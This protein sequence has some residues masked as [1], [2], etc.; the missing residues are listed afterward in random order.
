[1]H[2]NALT[3][4]V[5]VMLTGRAVGYPQEVLPRPVSTPPI[6]VSGDVQLAEVDVNRKAVAF[7]APEVILSDMRLV[8]WFPMTME[9]VEEASYAIHLLSLDPIEDSKGT[10]LLTE[11]RRS[12]I[13]ELSGFK[14][15]GP[16]FSTGGRRGPLYHFLLNVPAREATSLLRV[17]G[18]AEISQTQTDIIGFD[19][20]SNQLGKPLKHPKLGD[21]SITPIF[22]KIED[23]QVACRLRLPKEHSLLDDWTLMRDRQPLRENSIETNGKDVPKGTI[24]ETRR[25]VG[26][27]T[28]NLSLYIRFAVKSEPKKFEFDFRDI[29][30]P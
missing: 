7:A 3:L 28:D 23:G 6:A 22:L 2:R 10:Q 25:F 12:E 29:P 9:P 8:F 18:T 5:V 4:T 13:R 14:S 15:G 11:K 21:F 17:K 19:N 24:D 27:A 26:D 20:F 30:L 1:M 16:M